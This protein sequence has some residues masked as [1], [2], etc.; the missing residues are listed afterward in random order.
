[1]DSAQHG[2]KAWEQLSA[3][4]ALATPGGR[5]QVH[6]PLQ[7]SR[8]L[9]VAL[10]DPCGRSP[11]RSPALQGHDTGG[12][13]R[14][15]LAAALTLSLLAPLV[16]AADGLSASDGTWPR[17]QAR[18]WVGASTGGVFGTP[19]GSGRVAGASLM[20]DYYFGSLGSGLRVQGFRA[21][22]GL[23]VG[24]LSSPFSAASA[25]GVSLNG[26]GGLRG[27]G[28]GMAGTSLPG[29][30]G[31]DSGEG[32]A[33]P[34]VGLGYSSLSGAGGWGFSAD[35]GVVAQNPAGAL[36][37]GRALFGP[38]RGLEDA[39]RQMRL[40]PVLQFGVRYAF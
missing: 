37:M 38:A 3:R 18:L 29:D 12:L 35:L 31:P 34:Y 4:D 17:W 2:D 21:T 22:S 23:L 15:V 32:S 10:L 25:T 33:M 7:D 1:M 40:A 9:G 8:L 5:L 27:W 19:E 20:G 14:R 26:A 28:W 13:N 6:R 11:L 30:A 39:V 36:R 16:H 24:S